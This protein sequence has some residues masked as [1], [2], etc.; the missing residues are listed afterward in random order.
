MRSAVWGAA[1]LGLSVISASWSV[2]S[3]L[4]IERAAT[5][6]ALF[7]TGVLLAYAAE[8]DAVLRRRSL[9]GLACGGIAVA[10][11]R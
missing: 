5:L 7:L 2:D 9:A 11:I 3:R 10:V 4:T 1:F 8:E 6:G